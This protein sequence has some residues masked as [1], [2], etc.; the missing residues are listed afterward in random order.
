MGL[1]LTM[2]LSLRSGLAGVGS[3][4][5]VT[6]YD[7]AS[8]AIFNAFTTP[9]TVARKG[10]I[11][12][13]VKALKATSVWAALDC[14]YVLAAADSQAALVNWKNPANALSAVSA[15]TFTTDRGFTGNGT[16]SY[17]QGLAWSAIS[18]YT[19]NSNSLFDWVLNS[20]VAGNSEIGS[21]VAGQPTL[22][23][24]QST[25]LNAQA[26][27][28]NATSVTVATATGFGFTGAFRTSSAD[29]VFQ[30]DGT[31]ATQTQGTTG[32]PSGNFVALKTGVAGYTTRQMALA[33]AGGGLSGADALSA[34]SAFLAYM[35]AVGAA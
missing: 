23:N 25:A 10:V 1:S 34:Y 6:V 11:D 2:D 8:V 35:Q 7:P 16:S 5:S 14:L 9:P 19:L 24:A 26:R 31:Q 3:I 33:G 4:G 29:F 20:V 17:L 32:V 13:T 15:P 30:R 18:Q 27:S 21:D 22:L 28:S 12:T